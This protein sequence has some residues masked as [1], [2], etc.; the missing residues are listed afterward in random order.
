MLGV[1]S[2]EIAG[3]PCIQAIQFCPTV[4]NPECIFKSPTIEC[5]SKCPG[6]NE[7][8]SEQAVGAD[9]APCV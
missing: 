1:E 3:D 8:C 4:C 2:Q 6:E 5:I 7:W 9:T